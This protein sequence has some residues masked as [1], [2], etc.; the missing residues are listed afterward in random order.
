MD[1]ASNSLEP[2]APPRRRWL[3]ALRNAFATGLGSVLLSLPLKYLGQV[4]EVVVVRLFAIVTLGSA[5]AYAVR[6][7]MHVDVLVRRGARGRAHVVVVALEGFVALAFLACGPYCWFVPDGG[8]QFVTAASLVS[9]VFGLSLAMRW[10]AK[11]RGV[12]TGTD[13]APH[14]WLI[15]FIRESILEPVDH[16]H[17]FN[18]LNERFDQKA[19]K[20]RLSPLTLWL[21]AS[22]V[23]VASANGPRV[24]PVAW[25]ALGGKGSAAL[26]A[27][28]TVAEEESNARGWSAPEAGGGAGPSVTARP[29]EEEGLPSYEVLCGKGLTPGEPA[30]RA[31]RRALYRQWLNG[32]VGSIVAGCARPARKLPNDSWFA[33]GMCDNEV[34]SLAIGSPGEYGALL[35]WAPARFAFEKAEAGTLTNA[36]SSQLIGEGEV[37]SLQTTAGTYLFM[38]DH[39]PDDE[40][41]LGREAQSCTDLEEGAV[42][43]VILPP[44]LSRL[45]S[46]QVKL[47]RAWFWAILNEPGA[48]DGERFI[49]RDPRPGVKRE[50]VGYCRTD[51]DCEL[52]VEGVV[53]ASRGSGAIDVESILREAPTVP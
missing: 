24:A 12:A 34:R 37:Y 15:V 19:P 53:S 47:E 7:E 43:F 6:T 1:N 14:C 48:D 44:A 50:I 27:P 38:R 39:L 2:G 20:G 9:A 45:W 21:C 41:A 22:L 49:F 42:P 30:P 26:V 11:T 16:V 35:L 8:M 23:T 5:I 36:T 51:T 13:V 28:V 17:S 40:S 32:G 10:L 52:R 18:W 3:I 4:P 46:A 25:E 31:Q 29:A 33:V